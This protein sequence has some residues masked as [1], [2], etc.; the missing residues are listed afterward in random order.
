MRGGGLTLGAGA[1]IRLSQALALELALDVASG[2]IQEVEVGNITVAG[3]GDD[4]YA[5]ARL[6]LGLV[7]RP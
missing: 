7:W 6:G 2:T 4:G 3:E 1:D 5:T